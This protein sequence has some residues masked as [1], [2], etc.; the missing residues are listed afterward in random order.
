MAKNK[1]GSV[2]PLREQRGSEKYRHHL[3]GAF[4]TADPE[5]ENAQRKDVADEIADRD[6]NGNN[7]NS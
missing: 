1:N 2:P 4:T 3:K 6:G 5:P 7:V